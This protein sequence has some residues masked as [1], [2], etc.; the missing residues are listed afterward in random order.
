MHIA[1]YIIEVGKGMILLVNKWD[2]VPQEQRPKFKQSV[3]QRLRFASYTPII[4]ISAKL[5]QGIKRILPQ[6]WE[7]WQERQKRIP[8]SEVDE[9]VKQAVSSHPPPRTGSRRLHIARAYQ[10]ESQ[11][12]TFI[13]QVNDPKLVHFSYQRYLENKLRQGFGFRGVPL[14]LIFTKATRKINKKIEVRA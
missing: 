3:E 5:G 8:Q 14:K 4:Y 2:L 12:A 6:A 7:I 10:D 1:G 11:P 9:L 13:L